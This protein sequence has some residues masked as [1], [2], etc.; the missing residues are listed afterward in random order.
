MS[1]KIEELFKNH[2]LINSNSED[3]ENCY[4]KCANKNNVK[5]LYNRRDHEIIFGRR[6][7]G[8]TTLLKALTY[9]TNFVESS[10]CKKRCF[11]VDMEDIIPN[12]YELRSVSNEIII[13]ETYRKLLATVTDQFM[14]LWCEL[15]DI[16]KVN[17]EI[18][19]KKEIDYLM[20]IYL[21]SIYIY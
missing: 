7:T 5:D 18:Y 10:L 17:R 12:D 8:K 13:I 15:S 16:R 20:I 14:S 6:G 4:Y 19:S 9:Y 2:L 3:F 11:Y 1:S 21:K